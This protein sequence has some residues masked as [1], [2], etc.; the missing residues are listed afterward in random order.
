MRKSR[1]EWWTIFPPRSPFMALGNALRSGMLSVMLLGALLSAAK[2][3][4]SVQT[5]REDEAVKQTAWAIYQSAKKQSWGAYEM[6]RR[7]IWA[8]YDAER[9][10]VWKTYDAKRGQTWEAYDAE[11]SEVWKSYKAIERNRLTM[12][13]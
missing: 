2:A 9:Q 11:R 10:R 5:W 4:D 6:E 12:S 1:S 7:R 13:P 8:N 3:A